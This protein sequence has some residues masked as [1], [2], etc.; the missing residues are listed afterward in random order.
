[1][2]EESDAQKPLLQLLKNEFDRQS[3]R[4]A[5]KIRPDDVERDDVERNA[6]LVVRERRRK[7]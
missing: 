2:A 1:V 6:N 3:A 7:H 5:L 4:I